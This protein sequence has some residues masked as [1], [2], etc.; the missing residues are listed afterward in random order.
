MISS[1]ERQLKLTVGKRGSKP[2]SRRLSDEEYERRLAAFNKHRDTVQSAI[3]A[4]VNHNTYY[5]WLKANNLIKPQPRRRKHTKMLPNNVYTPTTREMEYDLVRFSDRGIITN[6]DD[7]MRYL[8]HVH[9]ENRRSRKKYGEPTRVD[10]NS[11]AIFLSHGME[12]GN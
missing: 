5:V 11:V 1:N 10:T 12:G 7:I 8:T 2:G 3:E 4:G 6:G 9:S